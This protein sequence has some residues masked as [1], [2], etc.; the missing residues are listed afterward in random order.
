MRTTALL[1]VLVLLAWGLGG[2][3][4]VQA[5]DSHCSF[6]VSMTD[7]TGTE[8]GLASAPERVVVLG[9]SAAQT[10][11]EI[12]AADQVVGM[13]VNEYTSYLPGAAERVDVVDRSGATVIVE[14]VVDLEP[15]LVIAPDIVPDGTV[16][17]LREADQPV[18]KVAAATSIDDVEE[19]TLL[20][21]RL[22]GNCAAASA[23]VAWMEDRLATVR[24]A[25][26]GEDRPTVIYPLGGGFV[27]GSGTF[28]H[29]L[30]VTAGGRNVAAEA[31]VTGYALISPEVVIAADPEWLVL[32]EGL[33]PSAIQ[34]DAYNRTTAVERGQ[35]VR[36]DPNYANQPAPRVV[37]AVETLARALHP[38]AYAA[39]NASSTAIELSPTPGTATPGTEAATPTGT[40]GP[41]E[42][43]GQ[44]GFGPVLALLAAAVL[45][46]EGRRRR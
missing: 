12:D 43:P 15:D 38:E 45:V 1:L 2:S 34:M 28:L 23:R 33:P 13:P 6:P 20:F 35:I 9:P 36:M 29:E 39:A 31:N 14:R 10:M 8:V 7:S 24:E 46:A 30:I 41:T 17:A 4:S 19:K 16:D 40:P 32:N 3:A 5:A 22:T 11:W 27:A 26:E 42:T 37:L 25:V 21:G 44:P 18:F